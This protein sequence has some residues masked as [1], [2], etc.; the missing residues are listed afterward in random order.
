MRSFPRACICLR[1]VRR[2]LIDELRR[3]LH[4]YFVLR[5][6]QLHVVQKLLF[7]CDVD[8]L[9]RLREVFFD[10]PQ[11]GVSN[12]GA[13][14]L[15]VEQRALVHFA[16]VARGKIEVGARRVDVLGEIRMFSRSIVTLIKP[17]LPWRLKAFG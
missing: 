14:D 11:G 1:R 3:V 17:L 12:F 9:D 5:G 7:L 15:V 4:Q 8:A 16:I 13:L 6:I 10:V 2:N